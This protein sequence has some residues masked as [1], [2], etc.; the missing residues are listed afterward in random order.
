M[1][2]MRIRWALAAVSALAAYSFARLRVRGVGWMRLALVAISLFPPII[3]FFPLYEMVRATHT[4]N[5]PIAL[6]V[7]RTIS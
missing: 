6:I 7:A 5:H 1:N 3:F 2:R 4:A